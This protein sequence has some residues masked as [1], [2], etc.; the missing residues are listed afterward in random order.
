[1]IG[2]VAVSDNFILLLLTEKWMP[3]APYI[4]IFCVSYMFNL[5]QQGNLQTIRAVGRSD[6]IL[7]LEIIKKSLY[8]LVIIG[9][10]ILSNTPEALAA[11]ALIN[12]LIAM[13]A[14]S[15]PNKKLID[16]GF[17]QQMR[18]ILPNLVISVVMGGAVY[19]IGYLNLPVWLTLMAQIVGGIGIY[20]AINILIKNPDFGYMWKTLKGCFH[21][22]GG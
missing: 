16:Y 14:N 13:I 9:A 18:D 6:I 8:L 12:T 15:A 10:L 22:N 4:K 20:I 11:T 7:K 19:A 3:A 21:K 1:M 5:I 2:F 17:K